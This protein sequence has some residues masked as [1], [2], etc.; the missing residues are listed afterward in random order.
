MRIRPPETYM[1]KLRTFMDCNYINE[2][3]EGEN[4]DARHK[5]IICDQP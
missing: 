5:G 1:T 4:A 3:Q 2:A